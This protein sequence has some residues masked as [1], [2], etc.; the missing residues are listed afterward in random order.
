MMKG[1]LNRWFINCVNVFFFTRFCTS[2]KI[3]CF[4][5]CW[6][7]SQLSIVP[8]LQEID[9]LHGSAEGTSIT[10]NNLSHMPSESIHEC[11]DQFVSSD[12]RILLLVANMDEVPHAKL[13]YV[14]ILI[15]EA[16]SGPSQQKKLFIILVGFPTFQL[17]S[18]CYPSLFLNGWDHIFLHSLQ[19]RENGFNLRSWIIHCSTPT[20][21]QSFIY[22]LRETIQENL[23]DLA[24]K[25][26]HALTLVF[27]E[28][29]LSLSKRTEQIKHLL[30]KTEAGSILCAKFVPYFEQGMVMKYL[31]KTVQFVTSFGVSHGILDSMQ[32]AVLNDFTDFL[33]IMM[34]KVVDNCN[35]ETLFQK[36]DLFQHLFLGML[37]LLPVPEFTDIS[38][39]SGT[40]PSFI[41]ICNESFPFFKVIFEDIESV[42]DMYCDN[43]RSFSN[44]SNHFIDAIYHKVLQNVTEQLKK[45]QL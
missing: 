36:Y 20:E 42:I 2:T 43:D 6:T 38:F 12:K 30:L 16:E 22:S 8:A 27:Q 33:I 31:R 18:I 10:V 41:T 7:T 40:L 4:S 26:S 28:D 45:V 9:P 39:L 14:R 3:L 29:P 1:L 37:Q 24:P 15:E 13:N 32:M 19:Q 17:H 11:L 34:S 35:F 5:S 25:V 44:D 21:E 23:V